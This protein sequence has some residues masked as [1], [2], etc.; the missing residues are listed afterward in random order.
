M[1]AGP[2]CDDDPGPPGAAGTLKVPLPKAL[3]VSV[4]AQTF[5]VG[6]G[7]F[8]FHERKRSGRGPGPFHILDLPSCPCEGRLL[9]MALA[10]T[11][12]ACSILGLCKS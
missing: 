4:D 11:L 12:T 1:G 5:R 2:F 10:G 3:S 8:E 7:A 6:G 9:L